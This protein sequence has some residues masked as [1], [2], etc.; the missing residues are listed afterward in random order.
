MSPLGDF[1]AVLSNYR[2]VFKRIHTYLLKYPA[3]DK[4]HSFFAA[5]ALRWMRGDPLPYLIDSAIKYNA[6]IGSRKSTASII[7]ETMRDIEE[8]LRF[9]YV[10]TFTCYVSLLVV[11]LQRTGFEEFVSTIPDIPL[12][13]EM[14]ASSGSMINLMG[15]GLS[16]T[17]AEELNDYVTDKDMSVSQAKDWLTRQKIRQF[18]ISRAC[19]L[20]IEAIL[21]QRAG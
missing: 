10:R 21:G 1:N 14:G 17:T 3:G 7:R 19:V 6:K 4:R 11:A 9:L 16:R 13:L 20:E 18:D 15:L 12:F 8:S 2:P 5:L